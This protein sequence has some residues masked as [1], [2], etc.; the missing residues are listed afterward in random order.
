MK[1][2]LEYLNNLCKILEEIT[3]HQA[4]AIDAAA[5]AFAVAL[6]ND[7]NIFLFGTGHSHMLAEEVFYRAGGL[8]KIQPVFETPLMLHESASKSTEMERIEG[9]AQKIFAD[10]KI[11]KDD[12]I[13]IISNSGR[14]G[15]CVDMAQ[16]AKDEGLTVIV[17]TNLNHSTSMS[18]RHP[19]G[20]KLYEFADIVLD[21]MGC[22]GD[23]SVYFEELGRNASP[24]STSTGAAIL[25][26]VVAGTIETMLADGFTPEVFSSSNVDGGDAVN[27]AY[28]KKYRDK[29]K[30]L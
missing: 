23:A 13:V 20:K 9:Y 19:S 18:S 24:T 27:E 17:L 10:Y 28:L 2:P 14:N 21:N 29:I 26:A 16:L 12:V 30:S 3:V 11:H 15:V 1:K 5:K 4:D 22:V 25:N 6:E 7:R 8:V